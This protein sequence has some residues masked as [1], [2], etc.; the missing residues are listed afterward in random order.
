[1]KRGK[2]NTTFTY[3]F[4]VMMSVQNS[5]SL[6]VSGMYLKCPNHREL[7]QFKT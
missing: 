4:P 1:M 6:N 2:H 7:G 3:L 5:Q